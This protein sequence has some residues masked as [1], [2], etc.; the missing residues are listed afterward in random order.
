MK[1][2]KREKNTIIGEISLEIVSRI[3]RMRSRLSMNA[4]INA[5][6]PESTLKWLINT[7][8]NLALILRGT[9]INWECY[10]VRKK[11]HA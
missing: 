8:I 9:A 11:S 3:F 7:A 10:S 4:T 1:D 5:T 6:I 2:V